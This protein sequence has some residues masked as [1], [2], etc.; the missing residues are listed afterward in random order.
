L[1]IVDE[2]HAVGTPGKPSQRF[3]TLKRLCQGKP[4]LLMSG[5]P[6][7][8]SP[9]AAY[10][11]FGVC[12]F[13]PFKHRTFYDFFR[14]FGTPNP[15]SVNNRLVETYKTAKPSLLPEIDKHLVKVSQ[16]DAGIEFQAEDE[17]HR[18]TLDEGSLG[19]INT[20]R[21][22]SIATLP[23]GTTIVCENEARSRRGSA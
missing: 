17:V 14:E 15:I 22:E 20:L 16:T 12:S 3:K 23:D 13:T 19:L 7:T 6:L 2:A 21:H 10:Y 18:V 1:V 8:E 5:T 9:L 11:Q 4:V